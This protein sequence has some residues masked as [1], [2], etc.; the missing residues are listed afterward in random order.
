MSQNTLL[1]LKL[2]QSYSAVAVGRQRT[3]QCSQFHSVCFPTVSL[4]SFAFVDL[5]EQVEEENV[6]RVYKTIYF[7]H[8]SFGTSS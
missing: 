1:A 3:L 2:K 4:T 7:V 6:A 5:Y 8:D